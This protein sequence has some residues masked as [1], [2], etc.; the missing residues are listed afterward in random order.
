MMKKKGLTLDQHKDIGARLGAIRDE[1]QELAVLIA[2]TYGKTKHAKTL[3]I[4]DEI[5][6]VRTNLE[7]ELSNEYPEMANEDLINVYYGNRS[8]KKERGA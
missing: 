4:I 8:G 2:N 5:D 3:K 7:N 6:N 1:Y